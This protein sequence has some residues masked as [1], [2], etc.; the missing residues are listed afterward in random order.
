MDAGAVMSN[1]IDLAAARLA[2]EHRALV[3]A[4]E[5]IERARCM[6]I[7]ESWLMFA[8]TQGARPDSVALIAKIGLEIANDGA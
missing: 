5:Q 2:N 1:V 4:G 7:V 6:R 3:R 8:R